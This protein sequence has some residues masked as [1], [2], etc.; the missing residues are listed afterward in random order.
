MAKAKA[1]SKKEAETSTDGPGDAVPVESRSGARPLLTDP[2]DR[3]GDFAWRPSWF[4]LRWPDRILGD[5]GELFD[6]IRIEE[7]VDDDALIIRAELPG[8]DPDTDIDISVENRRLS[9]RAERTSKFEEDTDGYRSEFHYGSISRVV[10]LPE[11]ADVD[12][13]EA[14]YTDG[15]LEV[16]IPMSDEDDRAVKKVAIGRG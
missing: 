4:G 16:R 3:W 1:K 6:H 8:V 5:V 13:I 15:I 10:G 11:G 14:E 9:I 12:D 7:Y 2:W